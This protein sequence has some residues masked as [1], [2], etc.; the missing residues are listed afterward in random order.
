MKEGKI[1]KWMFISIG[2]IITF[3]VSFTIIYD[4]LIPDACYYHTNEMNSFMS[5]FFSVGGAD[6]GHPSPN[7][8]NFLVSLSIG[9]SLGFMVYKI[10]R[11]R[12]KIE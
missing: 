9:G 8:A 5:L 1:S 10:S 7:L 11:N 2:A 12:R 6:N 3:L 4:L